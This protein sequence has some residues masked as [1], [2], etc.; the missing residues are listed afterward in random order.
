[1]TNSIYIKSQVSLIH[2]LI[3]IVLILTS[4]DIIYDIINKII[5]FSQ[6][7]YSIIEMIFISFLMIAISIVMIDL[8]LFTLTGGYIIKKTDRVLEIKEKR[9]IIRI[10]T[11]FDLNTPLEYLVKKNTLTVKSEHNKCQIMVKN[12]LDIKNKIEQL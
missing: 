3:G 9:F 7:K 1:M 4:I 5:N 2:R 6:Y 8:G 11:R 12:P 10:K